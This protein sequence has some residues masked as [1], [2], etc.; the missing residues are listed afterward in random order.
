MIT[1]QDQKLKTIQHKIGACR[2]LAQ[3]DY[4]QRHNQA[5]NIVHQE[6]AIKCG[7]SKGSPT[8]YYKLATIR[9]REFQL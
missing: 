7:L 8:P 2:A 4:T 5:A 9:V 6:L 3:G 1:I